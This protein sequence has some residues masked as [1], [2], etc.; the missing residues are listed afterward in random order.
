M[1]DFKK[2][3]SDCVHYVKQS[4]AQQGHV[5]QFGRDVDRKQRSTQ[6]DTEEKWEAV[7]QIFKENEKENLGKLREKKAAQLKE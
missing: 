2:S 7:V 3:F 1:W 6:C 4:M 5:I